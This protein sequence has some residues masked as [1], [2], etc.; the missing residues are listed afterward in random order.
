[1]ELIEQSI[2][3]QPHLRTLNALA[4]KTQ[5]VAVTGLRPIF[6]DLAAS[7][8][9]AE[10]DRRRLLGFRLNVEGPARHVSYFQRLL[11]DANMLAKP[12]PKAFNPFSRVMSDGE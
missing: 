10:R 4:E 7:A 9:D 3:V 5:K 6:E 12:T 8:E 2:L 11:H 1:M